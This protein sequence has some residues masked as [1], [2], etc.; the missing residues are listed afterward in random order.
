M[1]KHLFDDVDK[2]PEG[3]YTLKKQYHKDMA[4]FY[5]KKYYQNNFGFYEKQKYTEEEIIYRN[6]MYCEKR[7]IIGCHNI[8]SGKMLDVG[9]GEGH[10]LAFFAEHG[11]DV[12]GIDFSEFGMRA[13][14]PNLIGK[15]IKGD[16]LA[17]IESMDNSTFDFINMDNVF[18]HIPEP[19]DFLGV[20]KK[21]CNSKTILCIKVPNDF[22]LTQSVLFNL[23]CIED[24][25]WVTKE[26]CE[27]YNYFTAQ[28][29]ENLLIDNGFK[30]LE[31]IADW[32]IDFNLFNIRTN[33]CKDKT[34]GHDG[35][36]ARLRI[37]NMLF[38]RDIEKTI[39]LHRALADMGV[40]RDISIY[41]SII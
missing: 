11:W 30:C 29:L 22:S 41:F 1:K 21:L 13:H 3:Y 33:Y 25:F 34:V 37:E 26:T 8:N 23:G 10:A 38:K 31:K 12:T 6:N 15:L 40:G 19:R 9:C 39:A 28:S 17:S 32:P 14:H 20:I 18:E 35:H 7:Y 16:L 4:A 36:I 2:Q 27:H 5:E 24:A